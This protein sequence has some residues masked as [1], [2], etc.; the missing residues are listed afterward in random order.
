[1]ETAKFNTVCEMIIAY[2]SQM[3]SKQLDTLN[4]ALGA[5]SV[6]VKEDAPPVPDEG[7]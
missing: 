3:D 2:A 7:K 1:M 4:I 6:E 5:L